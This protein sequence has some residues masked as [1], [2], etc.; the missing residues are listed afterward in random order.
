MHICP[1]YAFAKAT[2]MWE[3]CEIFFVR[4]FSGPYFYHIWTEYGH[5]SYSVLFFEKLIT[6]EM[7]LSFIKIHWNNKALDVH[8]FK[9]KKVEAI[10]IEK[11]EKETREERLVTFFRL[12]QF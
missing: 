4:I 12:A 1:N 8:K 9:P 7:K 11:S 3:T 6:F 2:S 5:F 10:S